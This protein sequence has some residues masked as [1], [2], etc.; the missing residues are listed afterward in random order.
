MVA[1]NSARQ[2]TSQLKGMAKAKHWK[3]ALDLVD[4]M[5]RAKQEVN[6]PW[7]KGEEWRCV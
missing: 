6:V 1:S 2:A 3:Q 4:D 7:R 5:A